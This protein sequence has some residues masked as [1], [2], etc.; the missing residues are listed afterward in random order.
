MST[1]N[2]TATSY[3]VLGL[4]AREGRST[5]YGL[6]RMVGATLGNFWTFRHTLL[7]SEPARLRGARAGHR[8]A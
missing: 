1:E 3:L 5:P 6:E 8:G 4:L 7:Y 2:L